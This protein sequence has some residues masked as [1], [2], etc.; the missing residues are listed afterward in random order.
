MCIL[1]I[2]KVS[3]II[4]DPVFFYSN[5]NKENVSFGNN[6]LTHITHQ[7]EK[8]LHIKNFFTKQT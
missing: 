2:K 5:G 6:Y 3:F 7:K 1:Q 4:K 8:K